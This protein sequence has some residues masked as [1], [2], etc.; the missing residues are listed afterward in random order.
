MNTKLLNHFVVKILILAMPVKI[1]FL[2][3][4]QQLFVR[5][6]ITHFEFRLLEPLE[7]LDLV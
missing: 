3:D 4:R 2:V 5:L 6:D 7:L 1:Q